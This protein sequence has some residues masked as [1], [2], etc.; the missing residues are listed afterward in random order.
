M[1]LRSLWAG[2]RRHRLYRTCVSA[3]ARAIVLRYHSVGAPET[4]AR[5]LDPSLSVTPEMFR[6]HVRFLARRFEIIRMDHL[7]DVL[8][9]PERRKPAVAIT[10]DDGYRDNHD[11]ALP[12]LLEQGATAAFYITT[13]PLHTRRG[14]WISELW[15]LVP[16][17]PPGPLNLPG[18]AAGHGLDVP[19]GERFGVRRV[20]TRRLAAMTADV[21]EQAF[22]VLATAAG[23]PRGEGLEESF[24]SAA[25]LRSMRDAGMLI[26]AHT[27]THP[28]LGTLDPLHHA[29]EV[30]GSRHDLEDILGAPVLDFAYPNPGGIG[31][32]D[33]PPRAS[34]AAAGFARAVTSRA[35]RLDRGSD[36]LLLPRIGMYAGSQQELV[37]RYLDRLSRV[38][39]A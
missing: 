15:R 10:F 29:D 18:D 7:D 39:R 1:T 35:S 27:R 28:H 33:G 22:D 36:S 17:L 38:T 14:L 19:D 9:A 23:V 2:Y 31:T 20:L 6:E 34:V 30:A 25:E 32:G 8:A 12:I 5:Y 13:A 26:G 11:V 3:R 24:L 4:V 16:R 21:R 37:L